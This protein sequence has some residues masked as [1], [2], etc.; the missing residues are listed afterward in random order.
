ML[1]QAYLP[2]AVSIHSPGELHH[3]HSFS[4]DV[5]GNQ[6]SLVV[7][8]PPGY[9][10]D[11]TRRYPVLYFQDGQN[12]F[13]GRTSYIAD[14]HWRLNEAADSLINAGEIEPLIIVG[15]YHAG[16]H[17][18]TEYT[19]SMDRN[20]KVGGKADLYGRMLISEI[21]PFI[22]REYR[23]L[24]DAF[25]TGLGGSS[26]GGLV[27]LYLGLKHP[28]H[29]SRLAVMSP[30][31]WWDRRRILREVD[32]LAGKPPL[33][34][35]LDMGTHEGRNQLSHAVSLRDKLTARGFILDQDLKYMEVDGGRHSEHDWAQRVHHALRYLF[36]A[37][38]RRSSDKE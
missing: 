3:H 20:F 6:R 16:E 26:L 5:L 34:V 18:I 23:T 37:S 7:Y 28:S 30:S 10:A 35:W 12:L 24:P 19:P 38:Q 4:S 1:N 11:H 36:P 14:Q 21:K 8:L 27:S 15:I 31:I 25:Y 17:R 2:R 9:H 32:N 22:D 29:F 33:R 13:D